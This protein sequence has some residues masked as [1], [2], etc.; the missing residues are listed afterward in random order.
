MTLY[1]QKMIAE[2]GRFGVEFAQSLFDGCLY[3]LRK[4]YSGNDKG[5]V[6]QAIVK[7]VPVAF[8]E[9]VTR[10]FKRY[11]L[12]TNIRGR[13]GCDSTVGGPIDPKKQNTMLKKAARDPVIA[14][15][16]A[17]LSAPAK[18]AKPRELKGTPRERASKALESLAKRLKASDPS[19]GVALA[20]RINAATVAS[21]LHELADMHPTAVELESLITALIAMRQPDTAEIV[22]KVA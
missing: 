17:H 15:V 18:P 22:L 4:A 20:E 5:E 9:P 21:E 2:L 1:E 16:E 13:K 3:A 12:D 11:G 7:A 6:A 19:A 14:I 10:W 8:A